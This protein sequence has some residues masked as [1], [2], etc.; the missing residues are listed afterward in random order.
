MHH[1]CHSPTLSSDSRKAPAVVAVSH[2]VENRIFGGPE[3]ALSSRLTTV[4]DDCG[5][6]GTTGADNCGSVVFRFPRT[7][8]ERSRR[9][10][11]SEIATKNLKW[12]ARFGSCV[13]ST[14]VRLFIWCKSADSTESGKTGLD[15]GFESWGTRRVVSASKRAFAWRGGS[16]S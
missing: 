9:Q 3:G 15:G 13:A 1:D 12:A 2:R 11:R 7:A 6:L 5:G 8:R 14:A 16:E 4:H 10:R